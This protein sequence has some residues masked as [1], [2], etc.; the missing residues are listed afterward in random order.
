MPKFSLFL[1]LYFVSFLF[2][3]VLDYVSLD[4]VLLKYLVFIMI[5]CLAVVLIYARLDLLHFM[6]ITLVARIGLFC[7][8]C[9]LLFIN[10]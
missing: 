9:V 7:G 4:Y 6:L 2:P 8:F 5:F 10:Y 3:L 1:S